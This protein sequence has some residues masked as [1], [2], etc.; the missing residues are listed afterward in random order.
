MSYAK[1]VSLNYRTVYLLELHELYCLAFGHF[2]RL[3]I[4]QWQLLDCTQTGWEVAHWIRVT[5]CRRVVWYNKYH[6]QL[7]TVWVTVS[8]LPWK[9]LFPELVKSTMRLW[10]LTEELRQYNGER[11]KNLQ[12]YFCQQMHCLLKHK[13]LQFVLKISLYMAPTCFGPSCTIIREHTIG[14]LL[15]LQCL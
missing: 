8:F 11:P 2:W 1:T 12:N 10:H 3:I 9:L 7:L 14:A 15:K 13:M 5:E 4:P 6:I